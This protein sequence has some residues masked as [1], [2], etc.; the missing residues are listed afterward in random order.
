MVYLKP[1]FHSCSF[2]GACNCLCYHKLYYLLILQR[3]AFSFWVRIWP[4]KENTIALFNPLFSFSGSFS[5][6][7]CGDC[8]FVSCFKSFK[9]KNFYP[10]IEKSWSISYNSISWDISWMKW[11]GVGLNWFLNS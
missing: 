8:A 11:S 4:T 6:L 3:K 2:S 10:F 1:S 5:H 9:R 7:W